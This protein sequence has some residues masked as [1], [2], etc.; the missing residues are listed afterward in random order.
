M[1]LARLLRRRRHRQVA[2]EAL[3][4]GELGAGV[5]LGL[6]VGGAG[7][8]GG[9]VLGLVVGVLLAQGLLGDLPVLAEVLG[10]AEELRLRAVQA[11]PLEDGQ[12]GVE[13]ARRHALAFECLA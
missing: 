7:V 13:L 8:L 5:G 9:V 1:A 6:L 3:D 2:G 10:D 4:V 12:R 11:S